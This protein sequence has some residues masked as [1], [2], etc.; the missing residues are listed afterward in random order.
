VAAA[1]IRSTLEQLQ[2]AA[3]GGNKKAKDALE[4][5]QASK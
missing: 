3:A 2:T 1:A 5:Y 4:E